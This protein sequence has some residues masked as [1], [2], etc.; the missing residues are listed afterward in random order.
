MIGIESKCI[1]RI[2]ICF[3]TKNKF[4]AHKNFSIFLLYYY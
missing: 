2:D 3:Q 4:K 1:I